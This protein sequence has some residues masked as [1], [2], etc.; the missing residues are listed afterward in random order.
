MQIIYEG[1]D[2]NIKVTGDSLD[3]LLDQYFADKT[4]DEQEAIK[5]K[6]GKEKAVLEARSHHCS[7]ER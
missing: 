6:F 5:A 7:R 1:R 2:V 3:N 4:K